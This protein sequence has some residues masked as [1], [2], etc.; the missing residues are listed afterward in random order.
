MPPTT[1]A[2]SHLLGGIVLCA[3]PATILLA[4]HINGA[5]L[6]MP[7]PIL[8]GIFFVYGIRSILTGLFRLDLESPASWVADAVGA[9][10]LAVFAFWIAWNE[11][12]G[13]GGLPFLPDG[14]NQGLARVL[15]ACGGLVAALV[16]VRCLWKAFNEYRRK[17]DEGMRHV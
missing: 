15:F 4:M 5:R 3:F 7:W 2:R 10:G 11:R 9:A 13:W 16:A 1:P 6:P 17:P 12:D 8:F 14:W